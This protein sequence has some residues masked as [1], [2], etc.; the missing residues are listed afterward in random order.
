MKLKKVEKISKRFG[1]TICIDD[2]F[3]A[4][5]FTIRVNNRNGK[6]SIGSLAEK[7]KT[8]INS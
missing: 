5:Q 7:F 8:V 2:G 6:H 3:C 4:Y 1:W